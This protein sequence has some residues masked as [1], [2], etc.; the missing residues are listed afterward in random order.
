MQSTILALGLTALLA[1]AACAPAEP[2][3]P[4]FGNAVRHNMAVHIVNPD[5]GAQADPTPM[6]GARA[7]VAI[8]RYRDGTATGTDALIKEVLSTSGKNK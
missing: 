5:A 8:K 2:P 4:E 1:T 6:D 7:G 3:L